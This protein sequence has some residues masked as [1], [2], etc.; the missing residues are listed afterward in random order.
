MTEPEARE[1]FGDSIKI[2][3][4]QFTGMY[5]AMMEQEEKGPTAYK[6]ICQG[7]NE[8]VVGLHILGQGSSEILQGFGV[9][10]KM[11]ATKQDFDNCVVC[12]RSFFPHFLDC[13]V[14]WQVTTFVMRGC[15]VPCSAF[16]GEATLASTK[17]HRRHEHDANS[18][19]V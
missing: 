2:Y 11:G 13:R 5:Y 9:A 17:V 16:C 7:E 12:I 4:T 15:L 8:K 1:K 14:R 6:I 19:C 18:C 10:I 3:Q